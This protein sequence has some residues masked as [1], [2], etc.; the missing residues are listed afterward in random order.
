MVECKCRGK[1]LSVI[2][3]IPIIVTA[4]IGKVHNLSSPA[5]GT[6]SAALAQDSGQYHENNS[7]SKSGV[8]H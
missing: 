1:K 3:C 8:T 2:T 6:G 5:L 7:W 4:S